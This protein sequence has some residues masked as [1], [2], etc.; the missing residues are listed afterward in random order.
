MRAWPA[1]SRALVLGKRVGYGN[2]N[3]SPYNLASP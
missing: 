1:S 2:D 3:M